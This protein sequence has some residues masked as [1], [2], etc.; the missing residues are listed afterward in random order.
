MQVGAL[1]VVEKPNGG[2]IGSTELL[3]HLIAHV[4]SI[5]DFVLLTVNLSRST[6]PVDE[7]TLPSWRPSTVEIRGGLAEDLSVSVAVCLLLHARIGSWRNS[8]PDVVTTVA[9]GDSDHPRRPDR[10]RHPYRV[11]T[12]Q[13]RRLRLLWRIRVRRSTSVFADTAADKWRDLAE[14]RFRAV[15]WLVLFIAGDLKTAGLEL[16]DTGRA[17]HYDIVHTSV[18]ELVTRMLGTAHRVIPNPH[19]EPG[20]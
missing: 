11:R 5:V 14:R 15:P 6:I 2:T 8:V 3:S 1:A 12:T 4:A 19:Y 9:F 7:R 18:A 17:P 16:W 10:S 20:G 13:L